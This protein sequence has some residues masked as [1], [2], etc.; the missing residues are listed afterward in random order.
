MGAWQYV[1]TIGT[2]RMMHR[3]YRHEGAGGSGREDEWTERRAKESQVDHLQRER[4][5]PTSSVVSQASPSSL[6][7]GVRYALLTPIIELCCITAFPSAEPRSAVMARLRGCR[8][9]AH[10]RPASSKDLHSR[11]YHVC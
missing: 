8:D 5:N 3:G 4:L 7:L 6:G 11:A 1:A 10:V 9:Q 2:T